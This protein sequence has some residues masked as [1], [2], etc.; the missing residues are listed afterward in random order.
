MSWRC[1]TFTVP[2]VEVPKRVVHT[3]KRLRLWKKISSFRRRIYSATFSRCRR[4]LDWRLWKR[5]KD[6]RRLQLRFLWQFPIYPAQLYRY[7]KRCVHRGSRNGTLYALQLYQ[8]IPALHLRGS[9]HLYSWSRLYRQWISVNAAPFEKRDRSRHAQVYS[10]YVYRRVPH[11]AGSDRP[12]L[13]SLKTW[14]TNT[15]KKAAGLTAEWLSE[16]Y[17]KAEQCLL[18]SCSGRRWIY[19]IR[20]GENSSFL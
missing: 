19:Q 17:G 5:R 6:Q 1:M 9:L 8:G 7:P 12:C 3:K 20:V 13:Q 18:R 10:E 16:E 14:H 4:R 15:W 2:L 11:Y